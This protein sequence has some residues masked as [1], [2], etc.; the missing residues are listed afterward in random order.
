[1]DQ[2]DWT[3]HR[4]S[5]DVEFQLPSRC[6]RNRNTEE[7]ENDMTQHTDR[8]VGRNETIL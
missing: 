5:G 3:K 6:D 8:N 2:I 4:F 1:M 7:D